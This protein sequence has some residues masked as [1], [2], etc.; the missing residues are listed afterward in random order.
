MPI[1]LDLWNS[2]AAVFDSFDRFTYAI[3]AIIV[4]GAGFV[5]PNM[6]SIVTATFAALVTFALAV[7]ARTALSTQDAG[8][9]V[10]AEW[11]NLLL[12]Q[13]HTL[14]PYAVVFA[15]AIAVIHGLRAL[16]RR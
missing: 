9:V 2:V 3:M 4:V 8:T 15:A 1:L 10:R 12:L 11:D 13:M 7:F 14:L 6:A 5:M 16:G